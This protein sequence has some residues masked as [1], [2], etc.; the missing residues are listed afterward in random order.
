MA[1]SSNRGKAAEKKLKDFFSKLSGMADTAFM[2]LPDAYAGSMVATLA[3]YLVLRQGVPIL[4]ECKSTLHEYRLPHQNFGPDQVARMA[5]WQMA[6]AVPLVMVYHE[7][8]DAWRQ[9]PLSVFQTREGGSWDFRGIPT[10][11]LEDAFWGG[12]HTQASN[13]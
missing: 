11:T 4:V 10:Q 9:I 1:T 7:K 5:M 2:K 12:L 13:Y 8:L 3:D 6:G